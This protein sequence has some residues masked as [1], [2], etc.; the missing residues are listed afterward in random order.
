MFFSLNSFAQDYP[1]HLV[2][3]M[4]KSR[5]YFEVYGQKSPSEIEDGIY[6]DSESVLFSQVDQINGLDIIF[7]KEEIRKLKAQMVKLIAESFSK[8]QIEAIIRVAKSPSVNKKISAKFFEVALEY[9]SGKIL[10]HS[11]NFLLSPKLKTMR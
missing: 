1:E 5:D 6:D 11:I 8:E 3:M 10:A 2:N 7:N 4:E 9:K